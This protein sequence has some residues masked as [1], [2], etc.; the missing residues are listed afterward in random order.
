MSY[1]PIKKIRV[2]K[3]LENEPDLSIKAIAER[4]GVS[5]STVAL[6][7]RRRKDEETKKITKAKL[8]SKTKA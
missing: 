4:F 3:V 1:L 8:K 5:E 6:W 2:L 7:R